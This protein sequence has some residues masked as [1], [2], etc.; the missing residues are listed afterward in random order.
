MRISQ[1]NKMQRGSI[2]VRIMLNLHYLSD[3]SS[4]KNYPKVT[5]NDEKSISIPDSTYGVSLY[6]VICIVQFSAVLK[7]VKLI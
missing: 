1:K 5:E 4:N 2:K 6:R 7:L 3:G